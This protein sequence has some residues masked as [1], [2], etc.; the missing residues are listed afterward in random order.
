MDS[1]VEKGQAGGTTKDPLPEKRDGWKWENLL[2][3]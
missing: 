2:E 3:G 1:R